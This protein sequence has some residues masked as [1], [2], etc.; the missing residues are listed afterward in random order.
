M[1]KDFWARVDTGI[2]KNRAVLKGFIAELV[3]A[4]FISVTDIDELPQGY[5][6]KL[7]HI[8]TL[9]SCFYNL[10]EDSHWISPG[11]RKNIMARDRSY[12]L[13]ALEASSPFQTCDWDS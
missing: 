13:I 7:L 5:L 1:L 10:V 4:G 3:D 6:S 11:L 8:T 9:D 12:W 2:S